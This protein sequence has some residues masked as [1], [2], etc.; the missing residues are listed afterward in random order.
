M[1][2]DLRLKCESL[3]NETLEEYIQCLRSLNII[4]EYNARLLVGLETVQQERNFLREDMVT[5]YNRKT[6]E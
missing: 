6:E 1:T 5:G 2:P 3:D 4:T